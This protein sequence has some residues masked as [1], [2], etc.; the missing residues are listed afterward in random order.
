MRLIDIMTGP[1]AIIPDKLGEIQAI[2]EAHV[3]GPKID[4]KGVEA[5]LGRPLDNGHQPYTVVDG[6]AIIPVSG[7]LAKGMSLMTKIS[8]GTSTARLQDELRAA[9]DDVTVNSI[10]LHVDS[11]GGTVDGTQEMA[12]AVFAARGVK[13]IVA[14]ADGCA[15]S[16]AYWIASA[17]DQVF[18]TSDTTQVGSIGV[19]ASHVDVSGAEASMGRKTT[20]ITAGKYKRVASQYAPLTEDGRASIQAQV[21]HIYS[22][23]VEQIAAFRAVSVETVL[24]EMADGRVFLGRQAIDAGLVD[25]VSTMADLL[26]SLSHGTLPLSAPGAG[27]ALNPE[28]LTTTEAHMPITREQLQAEAPELLKEIVAEGAAAE[29]TRIKGVFAASL[30]GHDEL[31]KALALDGKTT[32]E[33]ADRAILAAERAFLTT[34][35]KTIAAE[36][37]APVVHA[38]PPTVVNHASLEAALPLDQRCKAIWDRDPSVREEF[39]TFEAYLA[40]QKA[41]AQGQIRILTKA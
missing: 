11:P 20:E 28:T 22:V 25:G 16:A 23:F 26:T 13:P 4:I 41:D 9:L 27:V 1:W 40:F 39:G 2:Y 34:T 21:D 3:R 35:Q 37:P 18:I 33:E 8:G 5:A 31:A 32:P 38:D 24:S 19:V 10:L 30:P 15:C 7:V 14:L 36:A 29:L 17:A 12:N 6:A